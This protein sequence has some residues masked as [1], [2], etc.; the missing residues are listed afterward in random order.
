MKNDAKVKLSPNVTALWS[1]TTGFLLSVSLTVCAYLVVVG[2]VN[3][4]VTVATLLVILGATQLMIQLVFFLH[5]G[6]EKRPRW[7][8]MAFSFMAIMLFIIVAGSLWIMNNLN[9]NMIVMSPS[10]KNTYMQTQMNKG[11]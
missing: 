6:H 11:F 7:N 1:L 8:V 2:T 4:S 10:Q 9:Y 5:F 3:D